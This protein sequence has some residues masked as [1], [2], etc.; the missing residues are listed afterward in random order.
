[1]R[2]EALLPALADEG[3]AVVGGEDEEASLLVPGGAHDGHSLGHHQL[4]GKVVVQVHRAQ[5]GSLARVRVDLEKKDNIIEARTRIGMTHLINLQV[6]F[7]F[8]GGGNVSVGKLPENIT[9]VMS[10][11]FGYVREA[12][13]KELSLGENPT[14]TSEELGNSLLTFTGKPRILTE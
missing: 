1:M 4:V 6:C 13:K 8:R 10:T 11:R 9:P 5:E 14:N 7:T 3:Q 2:V 12:V